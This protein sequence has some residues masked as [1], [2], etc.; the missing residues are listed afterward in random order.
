LRSGYFLQG[1]HNVFAACFG[2]VAG[3]AHQHKV[4]VHDWEALDAKTIGHKFLFGRLVVHKQHIGV[5]TAAHV[6][7]LACAERH[8]L[9][10]NR[11]WLA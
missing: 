6:Q 7:G 1:R 10:L 11:L 9:G 3:R 5:T 2:G 8:H 4:V